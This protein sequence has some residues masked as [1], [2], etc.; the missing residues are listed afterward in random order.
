MVSSKSRLMAEDSGALGLHSGWAATDVFGKFL[1]SNYADVLL[2]V[3]V[4]CSRQ[5]H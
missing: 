4:T 5:T 2:A 3:P 1:L